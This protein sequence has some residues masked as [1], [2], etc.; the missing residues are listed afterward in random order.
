MLNPFGPSSPPLGLGSPRMH[1]RSSSFAGTNGSSSQDAKRIYSQPEI[2]KYAED[3][4][5][6]YDDIF[7]KPNGSGEY[8]CL[9]T[10]A[11]H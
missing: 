3:D 4:D 10:K 6:D 5:E 7:G 1:A 11:S 2:R 8:V 9:C